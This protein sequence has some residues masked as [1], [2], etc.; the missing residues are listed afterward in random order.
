[1]KKIWKNLHIIIFYILLIVP[2]CVAIISLIFLPD[3]IPVH[4]NNAG[5]ID[6]YGSKYEILILPLIIVVFG[7]IYYF[8]AKRIP[9]KSAVFIIWGANIAECVF[10]IITYILIFQGFKCSENYFPTVSKI[11]YV[12]LGLIFCLIGIS[13]LFVYAKKSLKSRDK[14]VFFISTII[15]GLLLIVINFMPIS[16]KII[17]IISIICIGC[18]ALTAL[19]F[20][21]KNLLKKE[22]H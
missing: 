20:A 19:T 4:S 3:K 13:T 17:N 18:Y 21:V 6:R 16:L 12:I 9:K 11:A 1:M 10:N 15:I 5:V 2:C 22:W 8:W 7:G 14:L